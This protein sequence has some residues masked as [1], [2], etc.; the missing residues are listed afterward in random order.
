[1]E[2]TTST[3]SV[4]GL[5]E[6]GGFE[7]SEASVPRLR[8]TAGAAAARDHS[9]RTESRR[10]ESVTSSSSAEFIASVPL[11]IHERHV[12]RVQRLRDLLP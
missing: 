11:R 8:R 4:P 5:G 10:T 1:M 3:A 2:G 12:C 7:G 9:R 6:D